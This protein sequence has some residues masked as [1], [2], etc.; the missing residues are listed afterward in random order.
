MESTLTN[1]PRAGEFFIFGPDLESNRPLRGV[2]FDNIQQLIT[3]PRL[4][5]R[6]EDGGFPQL[7]ETPRLVFDPSIGPA[8]RDLEGGLSGYW[9][10]S[11]RLHDAMVAVD[12]EAFAFVECD[13]RLA[14]GSKG[15]RHFLCDV[16]HE[17]DALDEDVSRLKIKVD[18]DYVRGKFYSLGGGASLTFK[19]EL[20]GNRHVFLTPF[21][22]SVFCDR[23]FKEAVYAAG[24][25]ADA[26]VSGISFIDA[27]DI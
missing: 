16:V 10:I 8:P 24:I 18:E 15:A 4:I 23:A 11:E 27:S 20:L 21:N 22:P 12:P 17:V 2:V 25:P 1:H 19:R 3:P 9:L 6:P 13:I 5:L 7:R 26:E 14:D